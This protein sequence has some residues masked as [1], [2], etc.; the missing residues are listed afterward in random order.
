MYED[1][2]SALETKSKLVYLHHATKGSKDLLYRLAKLCDKLYIGVPSKFEAE[3]YDITETIQAWS[4]N[5]L[6]LESNAPYRWKSPQDLLKTIKKISEVL[7]MPV[8]MTTKLLRANACKLY[9]L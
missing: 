4:S 5:R 6:L 1:L 8:A 3:K 9:G 2:L 7:L